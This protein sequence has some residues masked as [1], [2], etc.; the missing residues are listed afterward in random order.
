MDRIIYTSTHRMF[1]NYVPITENLDYSGII[2]VVFTS[3]ADSLPA[4]SKA[5]YKTNVA[6]GNTWYTGSRDAIYPVED[7]I[8]KGGLLTWQNSKMSVT[9]KNLEGETLWN[10]LY[11]HKGGEE[12]KDV[13]VKTADEAAALSLERIIRMFRDDFNIQP[14]SQDSVE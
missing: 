4:T 13:L 11:A 6:Y 14:V 10:G 7:E 2:E 8:G 12:Y 1:G 9:I 5:A 3:T